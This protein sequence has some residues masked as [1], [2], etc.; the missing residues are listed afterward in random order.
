[1]V[2]LLTALLVACL[3]AS[4]AL[5]QG[6]GPFPP[7]ASGAASGDLSGTYPAPTVAKIGGTAISGTTGT[8]GTPIVLG[9]GATLTG[10]T[11]QDSTGAITF[12]FA[13]I[14]QALLNKAVNGTTTM[15]VQNTNI[16]NVAQS[17]FTLLNSA[18]PGT[19]ALGQTSSGFSTTGGIPAS[20]TYLQTGPNGARLLMQSP[21]ATGD[22]EVQTGGTTRHLYV[23]SNGHISMPGTV[24]GV[25]CNAGT[26]TID[27]NASDV[28]GTVTAGSGS[29]SCTGTF[30]TAYTTFNHCSVWPHAALSTF[31]FSYSLT[32]FTFTATSLTGVVAE[33]KCDGV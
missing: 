28:T 13:T 7:T 11:L 27:A 18:T 30:A 14:S 32:T 2:K 8:A 21:A 17:K 9:T 12:T 1:M 16:G 29:S 5:G 33:Y 3:L 19:A 26:G 22:F 15:S 10:P 6:T 23:A 4:N 31:G 24:P 25:T 20:T